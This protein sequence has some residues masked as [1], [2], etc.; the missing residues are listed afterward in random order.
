MF[1]HVPLKRKNTESECHDFVVAEWAESV[2]VL[3]VVNINGIRIL[4][5]PHTFE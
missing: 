4:Y 2:F 3:V 1:Y 5:M